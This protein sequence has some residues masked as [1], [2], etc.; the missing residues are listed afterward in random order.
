[1]KFGKIFGLIVASIIL[2]TGANA[3]TSAATPD[4]ISAAAINQL[5]A[6]NVHQAI[7]G[8]FGDN[9][10]MAGKQAEL[11]MLESQITS[12]MTIYGKIRACELVETLKR[13]TLVENRLYLCQHD[14]FVTR[15]RLLI[16]RTPTG[17][18]GNFFGFDEKVTQ[19]LNDN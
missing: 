4:T 16:I 5:Q 6:G 12:G 10:L 7:S 1:M 11:S 2:G 13:G 8:Y 15:W 3:E 19:T 9:P 17:W 14:H 18:V